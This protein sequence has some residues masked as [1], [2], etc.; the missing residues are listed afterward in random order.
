MPSLFSKRS[1]CDFP[2]VGMKFVNALILGAIL[3]SN[4]TG[5]VQA[6]TRPAQPIQSQ[7]AIASVGIMDQAYHAP[8][9]ARP[10]SR[11]SD[12]TG[13]T[14]PIPETL[15]STTPSL[16]D[17]QPVISSYF[18]GADKEGW[19][20]NAGI[21]QNPG[22]LG[23]GGGTGNGYIW[24]DSPADGITSY[25]I[26]PTKFLGDWRNLAELKFVTWSTGGTW[27]TSGFGAYG[28]VYLANGSKTAYFMLPRR[29]ATAW[30]SF[31][32]LLDNPANW[33]LGGG[34]AS[35]AEVL[36]HV[37]SF[38]IRA[39][40]GVGADQ[41][42]LDSVELFPI[43]IDSS[44]STL[45][46]GPSS[47]TADGTSATTVTVTLKNASGIPVP[48]RSVEVALAS[49]SGLSVNN[50]DV[51]VGQYISIGTTN[52]SGIVTATSRTVVAGSR[53]FNARSEEGVIIQQ[54]AVDFVAGPVNPTTSLITASPASVPSDGHTPITIT[55]TA[56]DSHNN[57]IEGATVVLQSTGNAVVTQPT[58]PTNTL[59]KANGQI[60]NSSGQ[61]VVI[62]AKVN[63]VTIQGGASIVFRGADMQLLLTAPQV[64]SVGAAIQYHVDVRNIYSVAVQNA[65]LQV[66]LP[67]GVNYTNSNAPI[68]P[69]KNGQVLTWALGN[70]SRGQ[71][72]VFTIFCSLT[73]SPPAGTALNIQGLLTS[74]T[75]E[76]SLTNN[77][78]TAITQVV[79]GHSF[80]VS[81][82]PASK[83]LSA[84]ASAAYQILI[85][86]TGLLA[87]SFNIT[88]SG[89]DPSWY[90]LSEA[91]FNLAPGEVKSID[92]SLQ[93]NGCS[94]A[95]SIPFSVN[96]I[97][98]NQTVTKSAQ[99]IAQLGPVV[100]NIYPESNISSGSRDVTFSWKSDALSA[101]TLHI[102]PAGQ[103][104]QEV[105]YRTSSST[106]HSV[107]VTGLVRNAP[108]TW[109]V[110]A[111][112]ECGATTTGTRQFTVSNGVV[113][114]SHDQTYTINRDY[115]QTVMVP[116]T[117]LD[118][119]AH[120]IHMEI[121]A[122]PYADLTV[123][124]RGSGSIDQDITLLPGE[125]R[126][127]QLAFFTQDAELNTYV[128][129]AKLTSDD[130]AETISDLATIRAK[131]LF[132]ANYTIEAVHVDPVLNVTTYRVKNSD[133]GQPI[134]DLS[135]AALDQTTGL[136]ANVLLTPQIY[137]ARLG[138]GEWLE[139]QAIPQYS[140]DQVASVNNLGSGFGLLA[141]PK[142][143][144]VNTVSFDLVSKVKD[145]VQ[146]LPVQQ[147]CDGNVYAVT[148]DGPRAVALPFHT[149]YCPNRP[150]ILIELL[151][152]QF[153]SNSKI[154][155][156]L[157]QL[158]F[159]PAAIAE[160]HDMTVSVNGHQVGNTTNTI[161]DGTYSFN[162]NS[163]HI[164]Q[165]LNTGAKQQININAN[166][167][168]FAHYQIGSAGKLYIAMDGV[169]L[170]I[171]ADSLEQAKDIA[172]QLYGFT[173]PPDYINVA[174]E[175]PAT[176]GT[177]TL[178][179]SGL[180]N[181]RAQVMDNLVPYVNLYS[182][183][184]EVEYLD[185]PGTPSEHF[186][187]FD[188]GEAGHGD[189]AANDRHFNAHWLPKWGGE[190]R[191]T[192]TTIAL[193]G[194]TAQATKTFFVNAQPDFEV[195]N[196]FM[197]KIAREGD[198]VEVQVDIAN[199]GFTVT[200]PVLVEFRYYNA[201]DEGIKIGN[202]IYTSQQEL[203]GTTLN[204][205]FDHGEAVTIRDNTFT[206]PAV[207]L[208]YVEVVL[209]PQT[210]P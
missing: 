107:T 90:T 169:T 108:Y 110:E 33:V 82:S 173:K 68:A 182:V 8:V 136:P 106:T 159:S 77:S 166:F 128:I 194:L 47:V 86:N 55:V 19:G 184:A 59:G 138:T 80:S 42:G 201:T 40:Y 78:S 74:A 132:E 119:V 7:N 191:L 103:P 178:D 150:N 152:S 137:H 171:C 112:S 190:V 49:G 158:T 145:L 192:V 154:L 121:A 164:N 105:N 131:V 57:L 204:S 172:Q 207:H 18:N 87:D 92:L 62:S 170:F 1:S 151:L 102:Y 161:P 22:S 39:E 48:N 130:G 189:T 203:F 72:I 43:K 198:P 66:T 36:S 83:T 24:T 67:N 95:G 167:Q 197:E 97:S 85:D 30:D 91:S 208:Y 14:S 168:N 58:T 16:L 163:S 148:F 93:A 113:F 10:E 51:S 126:S 75:T 157:L 27:Y 155:D 187:M 6:R 94:L 2:R 11:M 117:N 104:T 199:N 53:V 124:F 61:T 35:L 210:Q 202:P 81:L 45:T 129:T 111:T 88:L 79:D 63:G 46:V 205:T 180:L 209:D 38:Q 26:A 153:I 186:L 114:K 100:T 34:A 98:S 17:Q 41:S 195:K 185:Q 64:Q 177:V 162:I 118:S 28:D 135:I 96:T 9:F 133:L 31:S 20:I 101:G 139:F 125:T 123:N 116:V 71:S 84:N 37:T 52:A 188:D 142:K 127:V 56:K 181:I 134:T 109:Y 143:Y 29:P 149:W 60:I 176:I 13:K 140:V 196:V 65:S 141:M 89:L 25:Y 174:I 122:H 179:E 73:S 206:A 4:G 156:S 183:V 50:Q 144:R 23:S 54:G 76:E 69:S 115:D 70:F 193:G 200:G 147:Q 165:S 120:T 32:V 21:I 3:L 5:V 160:A 99:L 175:K 44:L 12:Q 15:T 146:V